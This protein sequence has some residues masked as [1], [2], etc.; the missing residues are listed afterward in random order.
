MKSNSSTTHIGNRGEYLLSNLR[1]SRG[2]SLL[3]LAIVFPALGNESVSLSNGKVTLPDS[4]LWRS[5][6]VDM[7][8]RDIDSAEKF[9]MVQAGYP[10]LPIR[11][12]LGG[13][14]GSYLTKVTLSP[15]K[16]GQ[17]FVM[18]NANFIDTGIASYSSKSQQANVTVF[19]QLA[20]GETPQIL[21]F[22]GFAVQ[23]ERNNPIELW[24]LIEAKQFPTPVSIS[25]FDAASFYTFQIYNNG[26]SIA[27]ITTMILLALLALLAFLSTRKRVALTCAGY[28]G[29]HGVGWAAASGLIDDLFD[30][31]INSSY[32]GMKLFPFAIA[33]AAQFVSDLFDCKSN[34]KK[35]F[36]FMRWLSVTSVALGIAMWFLPF[37][38]AFLISHIIAMF[39]V[40]VTLA[41]GIGMLKLKDF[42]AK[43]FLTGN[44]L[45]SSS[46]GYYVGAHSQYFGDLPYSESVV[47]IALSLDCICILLCLAEWFKL[48]Q[49]EF[50]RNYYLSRTD[51]MT[52]LGNR[53]AL[54]EYVTQLSG[55]YVVVYVD[56]DGLKTVNDKK[57]HQ[58]GDKLIVETA[59]LMQQSFY[60]RGGI[61][62]SGGD[63]FVSILKAKSAADTQELTN[64]ARSLMLTI[65]EELSKTW[66]SAGV[67]FGIA[68]SLECDSAK[69]C[70]SLADKRMYRYKST[71]KKMN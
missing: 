35:L 57:G 1:I 4:S 30:M 10:T 59:S 71:H 49:V 2:L 42:R 8:Y 23:A 9:Q 38:T 22:Q 68:T 55:F 17:Y 11:S 67:S 3:I 21:H 62:R 63:E 15:S 26:L 60:P 16:T 27:A 66:Y 61:F 64:K 46:L 14:S 29:L 47:V 44:L 65:S 34:H 7:H 51:A 6:P 40:V 70:I 20:D 25:I 32:W 18:I 56:L 24:V 13:K 39:W 33:C 36:R 58:E 50:N 28:L 37:T 43:Y 19:S 54:T 5:L 41:V 45:Y 69:A 31:S 52:K 12:A 48:Q 53:F